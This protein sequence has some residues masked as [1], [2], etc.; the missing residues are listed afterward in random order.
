MIRGID[1]FLEKETKMPVYL[2]EDPL[3]AVVRGTGVI[4]EDLENVKEV[5]LDEDHDLPPQ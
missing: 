4:L 1:K 3:T 5:L 2:A